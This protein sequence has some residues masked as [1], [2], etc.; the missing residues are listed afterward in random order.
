[1]SG[2]DSPWR[3][4]SDV[5]DG[6]KFTADMSVQNALGLASRGATS[7]SLHNGGGTG[8]GEA[9]NGGFLLVL[10]GSPDAARRAK[11][12]LHWDVFNGVTRRAWG[13]SAEAGA[14]VDAERRANEEYRAERPQAASDALLDAAVAA[15]LPE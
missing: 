3:E 15:A 4:T 8:W 11:D 1:M 14:Y 10:D 13:G 6:S 12:M 5:K 2:T 7:V 9:S